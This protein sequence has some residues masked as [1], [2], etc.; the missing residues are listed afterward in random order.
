MWLLEQSSLYATSIVPR[1]LLPLGGGCFLPGSPKG[2]LQEG[3]EPAFPRGLTTWG[4]PE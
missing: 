3:C 2:T 4:T 1:L